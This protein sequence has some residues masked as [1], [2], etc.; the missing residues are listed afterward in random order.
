LALGYGLRKKSKKKEEKRRSTNCAEGTLTE[1]G[2]KWSKKQKRRSEVR[3]SESIERE[4]QGR[5]INKKMDR[6]QLNK[7]KNPSTE[8]F[9]APRRKEGKTGWRSPENVGQ[10]DL[11]F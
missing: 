5:Q 8:C 4:D 6:G 11:G 10:V 7:W 2:S 9:G 3:E 1:N